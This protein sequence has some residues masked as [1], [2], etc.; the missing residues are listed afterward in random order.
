MPIKETLKEMYDAARYDLQSAIDNTRENI[1]KHR[2]K[3]K[4]DPE[5]RI[6]TYQCATYAACLLIPIAVGMYMGL[7]HDGTA[8][9]WRVPDGSEKIEFVEPE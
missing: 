8:N 4:N 7:K 2:E 5:V 6:A 1:A 9:I 3:M